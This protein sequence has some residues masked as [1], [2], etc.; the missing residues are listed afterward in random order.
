MERYQDLFAES[1]SVREQHNDEVRSLQAKLDDSTSG[2]LTS[3]EP[4]S[5]ST[6]NRPVRQLPQ[7]PLGAQRAK[8]ALWRHKREFR[9]MRLVKYGR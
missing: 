1:E 9:D 2:D 8:K 4:K 7:V 6:P 5:E 3:V